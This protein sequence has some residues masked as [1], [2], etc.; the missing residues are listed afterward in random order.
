MKD[1]APH[2]DDTL[3]LNLVPSLFLIYI[4]AR[5][6]IKTPSTHSETHRSAVTIQTCIFSVQQTNCDYRTWRFVC[7][8]HFDLTGRRWRK[9]QDTPRSAES[10]KAAVICPLLQ[11]LVIVNNK[12]RAIFW[13]ATV[14]NFTLLESS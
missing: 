10:P 7:L 4:S 12:G 5:H 2:Q 14:E 8:T 11:P 3:H 6:S 9:F 1:V 13:I